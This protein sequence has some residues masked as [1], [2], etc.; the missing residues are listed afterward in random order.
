MDKPLVFSHTIG[1]NGLHLKIPV[2]WDT[3][4]RD[5]RHLIFEQDLRP[6][7]ELRWELPSAK[8]DSL[9][10][11]KKI[12]AQLQ[13]EASRPLRAVNT[14]KSLVRC[15]GVFDIQCFAHHSSTGNDCILL[16]CKTCATPVL[17]KLYAEVHK[18]P[19][20]DAKIIDSLDCWHTN[21][22]DSRW[23][24]HDIS[25]RLPKDFSLDSYAFRFGLSR[26][27][28]SSK[29]SALTLCR[30]AP[31]SEHL[32]HHTFQELFATFSQSEPE[33][34]KIIDMNTLHYARIPGIGERLI[35]QL[36]RQKAFS[37]ARFN[38]LVEHDRI[39]GLRL[40]SSESIQPATVQAIQDNYGIIQKKKAG[41][42]LHS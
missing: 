21:E 40:E 25:F 15:S 36:R 28:F 19:G 26:L 34:Q 5:A 7:L 10:Q 18:H 13:G 1:W 2:S 39:T 41:T 6:I 23:S 14:P 27:S 17:L 38:H 4:V 31:A 30:L 3:I 33:D 29:T 35:A 37:M 8:P 11:R 22:T 32:K 42:H 9:T 20:T 12:I 16:T 24:I